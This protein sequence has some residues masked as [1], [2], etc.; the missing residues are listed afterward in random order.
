MRA[1]PILIAGLAL[2][3]SACGSGSASSSSSS[4]GANGGRRGFA[5][6]A[7][8][9]ACL[10][11]HGFTMPGRRPGGGTGKP[12]ASRSPQPDLQARQAKMR[13]A[14][15]A[16]GIQPPQRPQGAPGGYGPPPQQ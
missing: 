9:T 16:C 10:K 13:A 6:T 1:T 7:E 4:T 15:Q 2:S 3:V 5:F 8:Q 12:P 14:F 11:Q